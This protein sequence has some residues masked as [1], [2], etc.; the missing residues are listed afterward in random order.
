MSGFAERTGIDTLAQG[1]DWKSVSSVVDVGGG[2]GEVCIG[3]AERFAHLS[4]TVQDLK[5]VVEE[6]PGY[7]SEEMRKRVEWKEHDY[8]SVQDTKG[9]DVYYFR[10]ILHNLPDESCVK[11]LKA[12]VPGKFSWFL[13]WDVLL[14]K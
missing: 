6:A 4:F 11:L 2:R 12:Q 14:L 3:L 9:K 7:A 8:F 1:F 5:H 10:Y 13:G